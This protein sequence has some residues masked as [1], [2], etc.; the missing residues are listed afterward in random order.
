CESL[1]K[2][3]CFAVVMEFCQGKV[4]VLCCCNHERCVVFLNGCV[5]IMLFLK[6]FYILLGWFNFKL[7]L[8]IVT[9]AR[10]DS[11]YRV[12]NGLSLMVAGC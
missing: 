6:V 5:F 12:I 3:S 7:T 2:H 4:M 9:W 8:V 10:F 1:K 11:R